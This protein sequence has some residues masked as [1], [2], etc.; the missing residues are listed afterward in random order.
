MAIDF[1]LF[2]KGNFFLT[3]RRDIYPTK[4]NGEIAIIKQIWNL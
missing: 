2:K 1:K 3:K 4:E